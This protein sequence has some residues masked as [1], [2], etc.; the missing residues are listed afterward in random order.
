MITGLKYCQRFCMPETTEGIDFDD[1]G[2]CRTCNSSEQKMHINWEERR[3][4]LE[5]ILENARDKVN[6]LPVGITLVGQK[7]SDKIVFQLIDSLYNNLYK[8]HD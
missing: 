8:Y 5:A 1:T 6:K 7:Y 4:E 2:I 3:K